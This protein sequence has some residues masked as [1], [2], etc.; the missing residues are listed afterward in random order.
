MIRMFYNSVKQPWFEIMPKEIYH[1]I[2]KKLSWHT[3]IVI[4]L[5]EGYNEGYNI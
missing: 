4:K 3:L 1:V 2:E 5:K